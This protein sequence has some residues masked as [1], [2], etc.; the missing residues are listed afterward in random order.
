MDRDDVPDMLREG[1]TNA[2]QVI[3]GAIT[4]EGAIW[5]CSLCFEDF[6]ERFKWSVMDHAP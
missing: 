3:N 6:R 5:I 2:E 1:Y 4:P